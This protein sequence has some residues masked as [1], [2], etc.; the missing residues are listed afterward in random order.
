MSWFLPVD[1]SDGVALLCVVVPSDGFVSSCL[2]AS[3]ACDACVGDGVCAAFCVG[4]DVVGFGAVGLECGSPC[5]GLAAVGAVGLSGCLCEVE[6]AC[7][8]FFVAGGSGS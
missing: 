7:A 4:D 6:D 3:S 1:V 2:V 5:E 8:P